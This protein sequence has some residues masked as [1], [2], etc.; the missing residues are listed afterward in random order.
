M[1]RHSVR[2]VTVLELM[3]SVAVIGVLVTL[4]LPAA[5]SAREAARRTQCKSNLRQM[6]LALQNYESSHRQFPPGYTLP[7]GAMWSALGR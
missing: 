3:V 2:G 6:G 4:L 5:Q 7:G 1:S